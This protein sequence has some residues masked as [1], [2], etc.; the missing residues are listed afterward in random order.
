MLELLRE[1]F[2]LLKHRKKLWLYP[3]VV[4]LIVIGIVLVVSQASVLGPLLYA[5][6]F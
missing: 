2:E 3:I 1:V 5:G 6:L 4:I